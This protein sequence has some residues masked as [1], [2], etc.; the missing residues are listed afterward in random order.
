[1]RITGCADVAAIDG[2]VVRPNVCFHV[3][4]MIAAFA[5]GS[6]LAVED[7]AEAILNDNAPHSSTPHPCRPLS[8][9]IHFLGGWLLETHTDFGA[10]LGRPH[11]GFWA[12]C[13]TVTT[14]VVPA[15]KPA[16]VK[17]TRSSQLAIVFYVF[18]ALVFVGALN[19]VILSA[20]GK[21]VAALVANAAGV[22][23]GATLQNEQLY[24]ASRNDAA[25]GLSFLLY[26]LVGASVIIAVVLLGVNRGDMTIRTLP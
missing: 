17:Y 5:G 20:A 11:H 1:M 14:C 21:D 8:Q 4:L 13:K 19:W 22:P 10:R 23:G 12:L 26:A 24:L 2:S 16:M 18:V 7:P 6:A 15:K 25:R 9:S 3:A